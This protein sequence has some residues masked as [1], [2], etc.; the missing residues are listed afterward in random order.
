[1]G[2]TERFVKKTKLPSI[3]ITENLKVDEPFVLI[4]YTTGGRN[5]PPTPPKSTFEFLER[6]S[7][8]L[9]GVASSGHK[10]WGTDRFARA[11][12]VISQQ[13]NV[14]LIHKFEMSGMPND[15]QIFV[16]GVKQLYEKNIS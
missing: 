9:L 6:N 13:Y 16:E 3:K 5:Q 1:M 15:V 11:G 2:K 14:P 8:F 7:N 10:N 12:N 4:T